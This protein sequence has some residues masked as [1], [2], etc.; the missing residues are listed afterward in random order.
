MISRVWL[1][2]L[3]QWSNETW[4]FDISTSAQSLEIGKI[5]ALP[6]EVDSALLTIAESQG[7]GFSDKSS[8]LSEAALQFVQSQV[9]L[10]RKWTSNCTS[11]KLFLAS[12]MASS[13][14]RTLPELP[15]AGRS[16]ARPRS[17]IP[18][19]ERF[20]HCRWRAPASAKVAAKGASK[21]VSCLPSGMP[22]RSKICTFCPLAV[23]KTAKAVINMRKCAV[24]KACF[25]NCL[26]L[27][28]ACLL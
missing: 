7:R 23:Q 3:A 15:K 5:R 9:R 11:D 22:A 6:P 18:Q 16:R 25:P 1:C 10:R 24:L 8:S 12:K 4:L 17:P 2:K 19:P 26:S 13:W 20:N 27:A 14:G 28:A 21:E